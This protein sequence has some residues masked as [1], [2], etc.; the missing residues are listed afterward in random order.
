MEGSAKNDSMLQ[1]EKKKEQAYS[2]ENS[3]GSFL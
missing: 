3:G 2:K 1:R